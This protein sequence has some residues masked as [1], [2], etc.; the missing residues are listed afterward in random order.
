[1]YFEDNPTVVLVKC[2][3]TDGNPEGFY[4]LD[5]HLFIEGEH[6]IFE[7]TPTDY[8]KMSDKQLKAMLTEAG[9][10]VPTSAKKADLVALCQSL[11]G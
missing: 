5:K 1:M 3:V 4:R 10:E 9:M 2:P 11:G 7:S 8:H 6:E